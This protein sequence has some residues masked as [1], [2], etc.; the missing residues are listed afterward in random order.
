MG[1]IS[2]IFGQKKNTT[3]DPHFVFEK[4]NQEK[5]SL[6]AFGYLSVTT[7]ATSA[8]TFLDGLIR[9]DPESIQNKMNMQ[10]MQYMQSFPA[11]VEAVA[12]DTASHW[13]YAMFVLNIPSQHLDEMHKGLDDAIKEL[14]LPDN[15]PF[16]DNVIKIFGNSFH[17]YLKAI[18]ADKHSNHQT[19]EFIPGICETSKAF[20]NSIEHYCLEK[21]QKIGI[22]EKFYLEQLIA[23]TRPWVVF[24]MLEQQ[25]LI[26][27]H[28]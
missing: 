17:R 26:F 10:Y 9:A 19:D 3:K 15:T 18:N 13:A 11:Y 1:I 12:I 2:N 21:N 28:M 6:A 5:I 27:K 16:S 24:E 8:M 22:A 14:K 23:E 4:I 20:I 25:E 7:S